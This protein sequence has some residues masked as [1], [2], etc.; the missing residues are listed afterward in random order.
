MALLAP[1]PQ[2]TLLWSPNPNPSPD[3][4]I[5]HPNLGAVRYVHVRVC[6]R[7]HVCAHA[8]VFACA[9]LC[10]LFFILCFPNIIS[11][12][13]YFMEKSIDPIIS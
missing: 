5:L 12:L 2:V 10:V 7:L 3:R 6:A 11:K 1:I 13:F 4:S 8:R 9:C